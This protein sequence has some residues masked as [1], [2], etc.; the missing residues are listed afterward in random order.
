MTAK[1]H[2]F[3]KYCCYSNC[4]ISS[5]CFITYL[6]VSWQWQLVVSWFCMNSLLR[7]KWTEK[8]PQILNCCIFS[9]YSMYQLFLHDVTYHYFWKPYEFGK[10]ILLAVLHE[11]RSWSQNNWL[12]RNHVWIFAL[13]LVQ[14]SVY[15]CAKFWLFTIF[16][17]KKFQ[18]CQ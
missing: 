1:N 16:T 9:C 7:E 12:V 10:L 18:L 2:I 5:S 8:F 11:M 15:D 6:V 17:Y 13:I 4:V 3:F 14:I